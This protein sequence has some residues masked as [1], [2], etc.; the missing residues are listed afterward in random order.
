[1]CEKGQWFSTILQL[2]EEGVE[3]TIVENARQYSIEQYA[4]FN[5]VKNIERVL[6]DVRER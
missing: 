3:D 4:Y 6:D 5:Q 2:C 1:M